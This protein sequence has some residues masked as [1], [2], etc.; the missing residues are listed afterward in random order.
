MRA[1][2]V[3]FVL[4]AS[5][6]VMA[7]R[8][9]SA[10]AARAERVPAHV[11]TFAV[12]LEPLPVD[13]AGVARWVDFAAV[14]GPATRAAAAHLRTM[15]YADPNLLCDLHD[16][17]CVGDSGAGY[18][19]AETAFVHCDGAGPGNRATYSYDGGKTVQWLGD[20]GS[21]ALHEALAA[22]IARWSRDG[23]YDY[24]WVDDTMLPRDHYDPVFYHAAGYGDGRRTRCERQP[25][26]RPD[27]EVL[28]G[29]RALFA[30]SRLPVVFE[31]LG[32]MGSGPYGEEPSHVIGI[33]DQPRAAGALYEYAWGPSR[34]RPREHPP[35][36]QQA[37]NDQIA[38]LARGK[39][40]FTLDYPPGDDPD[41]RGFVY[42]SFLLTYDPRRSVYGTREATRSGLP[43]EPETGFVPLEPRQT[44]R[45]RIDELRAGDGA[46]R[47]EFARCAI[48][49]TVVGPCIVAVNPETDRA[50][51]FP[52][53]A[54]RY[55]RTL[56]IH[57]SGVLRAAG[58]DGRLELR[59]A[60]P[61]ERLA[62][63]S[64]AIAV[65]SGGGAAR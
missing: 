29:Y 4:C 19:R 36:R 3:L 47:R 35:F 16:G 65:G 37:S 56:A 22:Y 55:R 58:D 10:A 15:L 50:V 2:F 59:D 57:G 49:G 1:L 61:P 17:V 6:A 34:A 26:E 21:P 60:P 12:L 45:A 14:R 11:P 40:F 5:A 44:A 9:G 42:A 18:V 8:P 24:V 38:T 32:A 13:W 23:R 30:S 53:P 20:P 63:Q 52:A 64:W 39:R 31:G 43:V 25:T 33:L 54:G 48:G 46:Y 28:A 7:A 27:G 62:P 41:L 51:P